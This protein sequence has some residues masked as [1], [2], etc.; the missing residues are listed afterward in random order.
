MFVLAV[1]LAV[2]IHVSS[3]RYPNACLRT[4]HSSQGH[5]V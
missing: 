5:S 4:K 1:T 3:T 2:G